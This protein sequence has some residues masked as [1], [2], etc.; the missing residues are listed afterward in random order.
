MTMNELGEPLFVARPHVRVTFHRRGDWLIS[1]AHLQG[2]GAP[3]VLTAR[4]NIADLE[5][6]ARVLILHRAPP[7]ASVGIFGAISKALKKAGQGVKSI[8][9][10]KIARDLYGQVRKV[11]KS[12][13]ASAA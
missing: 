12:P 5:R 8:A 10:G 4:A 9:K 2:P 1:V 6:A 7:A 13:I 11:M 3:I